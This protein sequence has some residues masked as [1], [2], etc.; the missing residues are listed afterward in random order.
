M[1]ITMTV[2]YAGFYLCRSN[3]SVCKTQLLEQ[4]AAQGLDKAALG[5]IDSVGT[6]CYAVGK[7]VLG[8]A[9]DFRSAKGIF[10]GAAFA[11]VL[12]TVGFALSSG[13]TAFLLAWSANRS[14]QSAGW[15]SLT[16]ITSHWFGPAHYGRAMGILALSYF[17]GDAL[18]R[19]IYGELLE[20]HLSWQN[21][22]FAAAGSLALIAA[23]CALVLKDDPTQAGQPPV[24]GTRTGVFEASGDHSHPETI[25]SLLGPLLRSPAFL[26]VCA[27]SFGLTLARETFNSWT[28]TYLTESAGLSPADA[29]RCSSLFPFF[30]GLSVLAA[31]WIS[32][33]MLRGRRGLLIFAMLLPV[34]PLLWF[35]GHI[36]RGAPAWSAVALI[37]AVAFFMLGPYA[38]LSGA[39]S[40]DLGSKKGSATSAG[41][42]DSVGYAAGVLAGQPVAKLAQERG[43]G[44]AFSTLAALA[45]GVSVAAA[46][47]W[48]VQERRPRPAP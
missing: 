27:M 40:L 12:A 31:G 1:L 9:G 17:F 6:L 8:I 38:L 34:G 29:S 11:S 16:K 15:G 25:G 47:Y 24:A 22:F 28:P 10:V 26:L 19:L 45:L 32:D 48:R 5:T 36:E 14:A 4:Y 20:R 43:W 3:Y 30:G 39:I 2:G 41:I 37:S 35:L 42:V 23:L 44:I 18:A 21:L 13:R 46:L 7:V 33:R